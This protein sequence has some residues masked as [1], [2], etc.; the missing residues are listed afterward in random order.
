LLAIV[1]ARFPTLNKLAKL[2]VKHIKDVSILDKLV[3]GV[4]SALTLEDAQS[5]LLEEQPAQQHDQ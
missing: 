1:A 5:V 2:Q 3:I 4:G